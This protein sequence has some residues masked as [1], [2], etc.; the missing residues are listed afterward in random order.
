MMMYNPETSEIAKPSEL[1]NSVKAIMS[2]L[3]SIE[4]YGKLG[5]IETA[6][7][8]TALGYYYQ[9]LQMFLTRF[10]S[11][12]HLEGVQQ[13]AS[14]ANSTDRQFQRRED[15]HVQLHSVVPGSAAA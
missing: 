3:Q 8:I 14:S 2:V 5:R 11:H 1:L 9:M 12:R 15:D 13:R 6:L 10:S 7:P 4:N